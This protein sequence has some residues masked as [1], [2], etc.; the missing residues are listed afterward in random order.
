EVNPRWVRNTTRKISRNPAR[1]PTSTPAR[2]ALTARGVARNVAHTP[3]EPGSAGAIGT[4][5]TAV[6]PIGVVSVGMVSPVASLIG[7]PLHGGCQGI[8]CRTLPRSRRAHEPS[9][10]DAIADRESVPAAV[11]AK[12]RARL[13]AG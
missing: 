5:S 2:I 13:L 7:D 11:S 12:P 6:A 4:V 9:G 10:H 3:N 1:R 8:R